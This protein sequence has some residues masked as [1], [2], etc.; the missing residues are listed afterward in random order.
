MEPKIRSIYYL[1]LL[2]S[3]GVA[4][5][6]LRKRRKATLFLCLYIIL[7][8][9]NESLA[10]ISVSRIGNNYLIYNIYS[11]LSLTFIVLYYHMLLIKF[12]KSYLPLFLLG[13]GII[14]GIANM[15][16]LQPLLN[17]HNYNFKFLSNLII[18]TLSMYTIYKMI[19]VNQIAWVLYKMVHFWIACI[20]IFYNLVILFTRSMIYPFQIIQDTNGLFY[21]IFMITNIITYCSFTLVL[22]TATKK[23]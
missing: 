3:S 8:F 12:S 7:G 18:I 13:L 15:M 16:Y 21:Y 4:F 2:I 11:F 22:I 10:K 6:H 17:S 19:L 14:L 23:N 20:F 1:V 5:Y 9:I